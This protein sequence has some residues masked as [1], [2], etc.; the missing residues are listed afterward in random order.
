MADLLQQFERD[1]HF[2]GSRLRQQVTNPFDEQEIEMVEV[3]VS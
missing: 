1:E 3:A 2:G